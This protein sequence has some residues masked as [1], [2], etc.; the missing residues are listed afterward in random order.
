MKP[1]PI[2][3]VTGVS[4]DDDFRLLLSITWES[5]S[6]LFLRG[7]S[8]RCKAG[9]NGWTISEGCCRPWSDGTGAFQRIFLWVVKDDCYGATYQSQNETSGRKGRHTANVGA[10]IKQTERVAGGDNRSN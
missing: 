9:R 1:G 4:I 2:Q 3:V 5:L 7:A 8:T 6:A 10:Q